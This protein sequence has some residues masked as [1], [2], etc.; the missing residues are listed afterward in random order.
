V[1]VNAAPPTL[2]VQGS[3]ARARLLDATRTCIARFGVTKTTIDD[4]AREAGISRATLYRLFPGKQQLVE[5]LVSRELAALQAEL[6]S[7]AAAT[8]TLDD[9]LVALIVTA[10]HHLDTHDALRTVLAHEPEV[11]LPYLTFDAAG[12]V[13]NRAGR[14][15]APLLAPYVGADRSARAGEWVAR[16]A[17]AYL[18]APSDLVRLSDP[19][20]VRSLVSDFLAPGLI[21]TTAR[22]TK[23]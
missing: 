8:D 3:S 16:T 4:V 5:A 20:S 2:D 15:L 10:A 12:A 19:N 11:L 17:L 21:G 18:C 1:Q 13:L 9:L 7:V 14:A 22:S 23:G 6:V